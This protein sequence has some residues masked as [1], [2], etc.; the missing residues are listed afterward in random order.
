MSTG[1]EPAPESTTIE[2]RKE[3]YEGRTAGVLHHTPTVRGLLAYMFVGMFALTVI[4][5]LFR[6]SS[7]DETKQLLDLI[8]PAE[9]A[10]MGSAVGFYFASRE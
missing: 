7:W 6:A 4:I 9:T 5:A 1:S 10:L 3:L 2:V 8:L